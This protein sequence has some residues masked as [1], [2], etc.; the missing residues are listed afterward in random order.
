MKKNIIVLSSV[1]AYIVIVMGLNFINR[2]STTSNIYTELNMKLVEYMNENNKEA[3]EPRND[4]VH[5]FVPGLAGMEI[6][7]EQSYNNMTV[8]GEFDPSLVV[9]KSTPYQED[10]KQF[11][12]EPIYKGNEAGKYVSIL[13]NV[14]WGEAELDKMIEI[15]ER[16]GVKANFFIEGRYAE[17]HQ[18]QIAK[19]YAAGHVIGNHSYSHPSKWLTYSYDQFAEEIKKTNDILSSII[20]QPIEFFA[21]PAGAFNHLTLKA[22]AD[23]DMY[24]IMWT[25]DTIDWR[26]DSKEQ[27]LNLVLPKVNNGTLILMHPKP[28]TV[29][30]LEILILEIKNKGYQ[31]KTIDEMVYGTRPECSA[32]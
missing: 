15:F 4:T 29:E 13:V 25:A 11:Q 26:G 9:C 21:P 3:V 2:T 28:A 24:T 12:G 19:L 5:H 23:Q 18:N 27:M 8:K 31:F 1:F 7:Y 22:A 32:K 14:A 6:D 30:A 17:T 10:I 16:N 20:N